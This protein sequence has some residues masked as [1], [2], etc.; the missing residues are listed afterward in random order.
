[1]PDPYQTLSAAGLSDVGRKRR[2]NED[3]LL[4]RPD[5]GLF[6]VVD[7]M[8]GHASGDVASA[9]AAE[10][11]E[12]VFDNET[13]LAGGALLKHGV[14]EANRIV[15]ERS[16][17]AAKHGG[18]GATIVAAHIHAGELHVC[19][20]GDSRCYRIRDGA[21]EALTVDHNLRNDALAM[22]PGLSTEVLDEL[23]RNIVTRA[24]GMKVEVDA[25]LSSFPVEPGDMFVL[26]SDGLTGGV[27]DERIAE[28]ADADDLESS[29]KALIDEANELDGS[30]NST[31]LLVSVG[32]MG[33]EFPLDEDDDEDDYADDDEDETPT[34]VSLIAAAPDADGLPA[35][36]SIEPSP[37]ED[38]VPTP[39][40]LLASADDDESPTP[41]SLPAPHAAAAVR[42]ARVVTIGSSR[43]P[44]RASEP[45]A[46]NWP[47]PPCPN[48]QTPLPQASG[49]AF[50]P[51]CGG[52]L[53][54]HSG[55]APVASCGECGTEIMAGTA[56][57][58]RCGAR[59]GFGDEE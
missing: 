44:P 3:T 31:V 24:L 20:A 56:F 55:S 52:P 37:V 10:T 27:S 19:H 18:M 33:T 9:L 47:E 26:C 21:I 11:L 41:V 38:E 59:H 23:P 32:A 39:I 42:I 48:C 54:E 7:G 36:P 8:G 5:V 53:P 13:T 16:G 35:P 40:S 49:L 14:A 6:A 57:C 17:G 34:P 4:V 46:A 15:F 12:S 30:D 2:H 43:P 28:L 58:V 29:C 45:P 25:A 51:H 22:N 1:M 50:C